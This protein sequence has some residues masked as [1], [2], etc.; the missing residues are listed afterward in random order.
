MPLMGAP[1]NRHSVA[2][3]LIQAGEKVKNV[4]ELL[5][6]EKYSTTMDIYAEYMPV[7]EKDKTA[8]KIDSLLAELI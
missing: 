8:E 2:I 3:L 5:G 7:E 4:Q 1:H 6:H